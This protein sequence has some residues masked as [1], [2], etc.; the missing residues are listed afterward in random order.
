M[1]K[2]RELTYNDLEF[3]TNVRNESVEFL[4]TKTKFTLEQCQNWFLKNDDL[5]LIVEMDG[6]DVGYIRTSDLTE[7][8][9]Y[10]GMDIDPNHRGKGYAVPIYNE[11]IPWLKEKLNISYIL[12]EVL[13]SNERAHHIYKK[14]GFKEIDRY[15]YDGDISIKM[16]LT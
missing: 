13:A 9:V 1:V 8:S 10:I 14:I 12:L 15:D 3:L 2:F 7:D 16:I 4:H 6:I 11:L 5:Y